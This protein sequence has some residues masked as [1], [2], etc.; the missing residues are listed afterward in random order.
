MLNTFV[1]NTVFN[2]LRK[3]EVLC[4][5][6]RRLLV[7]VSKLLVNL[8]VRLSLRPSNCVESVSKLLAVSVFSYKTLSV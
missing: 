4:F 7:N 2:E 3:L 1:N 8:L 5:R 6:S